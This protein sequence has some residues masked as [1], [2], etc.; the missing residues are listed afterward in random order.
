MARLVSLLNLPADVIGAY[1]SA[2]GQVFDS[3]KSNDTK[4]ATALSE[5]LDLELTKQ[6]YEACIAAIEAKEEDTRC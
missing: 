3:F 2:V 5:S 4:E 6:K 1:F